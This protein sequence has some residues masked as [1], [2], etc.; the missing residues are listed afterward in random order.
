[1]R[2]KLPV[3]EGAIDRDGVKIHYETYGEGAHTILFLPTWSLPGEQGADSLFQQAFPLH[4][5]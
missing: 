2:A 5:L 4:H 1:M 3:T